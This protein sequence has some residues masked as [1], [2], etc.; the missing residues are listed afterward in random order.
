MEKNY[1]E[2]LGRYTK[3]MEEIKLRTSSITFILNR[4]RSTG[5]KYTDA[6]FICLQFRK[7]LELIALGNLVSN[8][9][10]YAKKHSNFANHYHA[11]HILK[12]IETLNPNFYPIPTVQILEPKTKKVI[13]TRNVESGFLTKEEF[14]V[15][16]DEC[17]QLMHAENPFAPPKN[18]ENLC[19]KFD[20][21]LAKII[22]LLNHHQLQ[23]IDTK[24]QIWVLMNAKDSGNVQATLFE[25]IG[26]VE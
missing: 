8:K 14:A 10:E 18:I 12:D 21:W 17:S 22:C 7:I 16:Y 4:Q 23:L 9:D 20:D 15:V 13:E 1:N 25:M 3:C 2:V 5:Y 11:K 19:V 26:T 24:L 6:E